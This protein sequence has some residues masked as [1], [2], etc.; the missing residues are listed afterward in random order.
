MFRS[1]KFLQ[2]L[3]LLLFAACT[4][5]DSSSTDES[6]GGVVESESSSETDPAVESGPDA[7][8][9]GANQSDGNNE[10]NSDDGKSDGDDSD[11]DDPVQVS[12]DETVS[13]Q[14]MDPQLALTEE[15]DKQLQE[16]AETLAGEDYIEEGTALEFEPPR[17]QVSTSTA[18]LN[19][20]P[21]RIDSVVEAK[22]PAASIWGPRMILEDV[23]ISADC[24][25][26]VIAQTLSLN[27]H[28]DVGS[29]RT[30]MVD[31]G[32]RETLRLDDWSGD[33]ILSGTS[34]IAFD[35]S[36][37]EECA[38]ILKGKSTLVGEVAL[39]DVLQIGISG[40]VNK[41][42]SSSNTDHTTVYIKVDPDAYSA[43]AVDAADNPLVLQSTQVRF[44][45]ADLPG[46]YILLKGD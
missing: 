40:G 35:F 44:G 22:V 37:K 26:T 2:V 14:G 10:G 15:I 18:G 19:S 8:D 32:L 33:L 24:K 7:G 11:V 29:E 41:K 17:L 21:I 5:S 43:E 38:A 28:I 25:V 45:R 4:G 3:A 23:Q 6:G 46:K 13:Y 20:M 30:R 12:P 16:L 1:L 42:S 27:R 34:E 9:A 36:N 39:D 31:S